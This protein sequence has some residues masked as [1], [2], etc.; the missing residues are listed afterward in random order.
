M[1]KVEVEIYGLL[2]KNSGI[3]L[4]IHVFLKSLTAEKK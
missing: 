4:Q 1:E 2:F 3:H